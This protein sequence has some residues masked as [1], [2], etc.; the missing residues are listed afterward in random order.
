MSGPA[1]RPAGR[2]PTALRVTLIGVAAGL[3]NGL[4]GIGGGIVIV[5]A[6]VLHAGASP[7][8]AVG[9]SLAAVVVLSGSAFALH[10][11]LG[12]YTLSPLGSL[13]L[14]AAGI[15]GAQGGA[16]VLAG[17]SARR[18]LLVFSAVVLLAAARLIAQGLGLGAA[19]GAVA[20]S[21]PL[22]AYPAVGLAS[23]F[24]AGLL[25]IGGGGMALLALVVLFD[26]PV[27]AGLPLALAVN[28]TNALSGCYAQ[29]RAGEVRWSMVARL[30]PG[31]LAGIVPGAA[32]A[33]WLPA[34][35]LRVVFGGFFLFIALRVAQQGLRTGG[36][37]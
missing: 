21:P 6:M 23:G 27:Q 13:L 36:R 10:V 24:L 9:T 31:A 8:A 12:G 33:L 4:L 17:W 7:R 37:R 25:G 26:L 5:P 11:V 28:V 22:L 29:V 1:Q 32:L 35:T 30:L 34:A 2:Q 19:P 3:L 15:V 20:V 14:I 18:L 16:R